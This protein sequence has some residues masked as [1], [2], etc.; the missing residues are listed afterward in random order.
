MIPVIVMLIDST[1]RLA[2]SKVAKTTRDVIP[3]VSRRE[4]AI[5][6]ILVFM[7]ALGVHG[8]KFFHLGN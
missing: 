6:R 3:V 7:A 2:L 5:L 8:S 1:L 4:N